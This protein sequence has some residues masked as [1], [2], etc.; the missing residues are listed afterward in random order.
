MV[1]AAKLLGACRHQPTHIQQFLSAVRDGGLVRVPMRMP[2]LTGVPLP[3]RVAA[4]VVVL[5][6]VT[7]D[8]LGQHRRV[9]DVCQAGAAAAAAA[10]VAAAAAAHNNVGQRQRG[11][12]LQLL[13]PPRHAGQWGRPCNGW[14][15]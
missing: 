4:V 13:L 5:L 15:G 2:M 8:A 10:A 12:V 1:A 7:A 14:V 3:Q 9:L 11:E 6:A